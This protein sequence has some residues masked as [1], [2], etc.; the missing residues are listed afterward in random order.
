LIQI[1]GLASEAH[2]DFTALSAGFRHDL[3]ALTMLANGFIITSML[4]ASWL[5]WL[6][7][8]RFVR[9]GL[10][11]LVAGL[12]TLFGAI[13]SPYA[14]GRLFWPGPDTPG[15][16]FALAGGYGLLALLCLAAHALGR[17]AKAQG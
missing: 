17:G 8:R 15:A 9:A 4:W 7:E 10:V 3:E 14:D 16:V 5:V 12:M 6:V 1:N 2:V 13:H 11:G